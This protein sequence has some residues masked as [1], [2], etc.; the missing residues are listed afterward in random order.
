MGLPLK[1]I[2]K[3]LKVVNSV[4]AIGKASG[5]RD[6]VLEAQNGF[7]STT[8][9]GRDLRLS[10]PSVSR[11]ERC[12]VHLLTCALVWEAIWGGVSS[13][14]PSWPPSL[15][16]GTKS[17]E[18]CWP[19]VFLRVCVVMAKVNWSLGFELKL[20]ELFVSSEPYTEMLFELS[21]CLRDFFFSWYQ[22]TT[23]SKSLLWNSFAEGDIPAG[24]QPS[25][26]RPWLRDGS[27]PLR[28]VLCV[29]LTSWNGSSPTK[30]GS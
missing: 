22:H 6:H 12:E 5:W 16:L 20:A 28:C 13:L 8:G 26:A 30:F 23:S 15:W 1:N 4:L 14:I 19:S 9:L 29:R 24:T 25:Q 3:C 27:S 21:L 7:W 10:G 11:R 17:L 18:N 2:F